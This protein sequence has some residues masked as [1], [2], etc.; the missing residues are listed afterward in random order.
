MKKMLS[1]SEFHSS[2]ARPKTQ[3][4]FLHHRKITFFASSSSFLNSISFCAYHQSKPRLHNNVFQIVIAPDCFSFFFTHSTITKNQLGMTK[5]YFF[6]QTLRT[7]RGRFRR[8]SRHV[9]ETEKNCLNSE[10]TSARCTHEIKNI[11]WLVNVS[12]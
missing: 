3:K 1:D 5:I 10:P 8:A 7:A 9:E 4:K 11:I 2:L 12:Y 6:L